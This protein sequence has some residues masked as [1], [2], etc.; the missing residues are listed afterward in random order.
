MSYFRPMRKPGML[1]PP[2]LE[3]TIIYRSAGGERWTSLASF[4]KGL[5]PFLRAGGASI[6]RDLKGKVRKWS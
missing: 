6:E 5:R 2:G 3:R 1:S 4:E